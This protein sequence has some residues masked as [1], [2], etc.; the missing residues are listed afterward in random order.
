MRPEA[1]LLRQIHPEWV[2]ENRPTSQAFRPSAKDEN[3]L[4]MYDGDMIQAEAAWQHHTDGLQ[5]SS[6]GVCGVTVAECA[7]AELPCRPDPEPFP[8]HAVIDFTGVAGKEAV[9]RA[10]KLSHFAV[11]R[12]WLFQPDLA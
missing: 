9:R 7:T 5:L 3:L 1:T 4:S 8:E 11:S 12:G 10:K 6:A 2:Q